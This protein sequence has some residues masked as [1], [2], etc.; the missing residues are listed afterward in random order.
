MLHFF[1]IS[2]SSEMAMAMAMAK[3]QAIT[4]KLQE[5]V[6]KIRSVSAAKSE[7]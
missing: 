7:V 1:T 2:Q 5:G 4:S 6:F 3:A